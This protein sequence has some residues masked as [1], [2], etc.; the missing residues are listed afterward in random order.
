MPLLAA[1][2]FAVN[3]KRDFVVEGVAVTGRHGDGTE[4]PAPSSSQ[5][6]RRAAYTDR[7]RSSV[8]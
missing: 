3:P 5:I 2:N 8:S 4:A 7:I 6:A 1:L